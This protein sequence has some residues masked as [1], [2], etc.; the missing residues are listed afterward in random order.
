MRQFCEKDNFKFF[1]ISSINKKDLEEC[2]SDIFLDVININYTDTEYSQLSSVEEN[3]G[4]NSMG[5]N[6]SGRKRGSKI[7]SQITEEKEEPNSN[8]EIKKSQ[9]KLVRYETIENKKDCCFQ[10]V[11]SKIKKLFS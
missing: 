4:K 3:K 10:L 1:E 2:F 11:W 7:S 9:K 5:I 8:D 6:N